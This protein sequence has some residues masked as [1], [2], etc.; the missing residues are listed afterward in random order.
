MCASDV[1]ILGPKRGE[2]DVTGAARHYI[3]DHVSRR[4]ET[5]ASQ[6]AEFWTTCTSG[7]GPEQ[8]LNMEWHSGLV[9]QALQQLPFMEKMLGQW[10]RGD[11]SLDVL[12]GAIDDYATF[13]TAAG[14]ADDDE[15][16]PVPSDVVDLLW[17]THMLAPRRYAEECM[18]ICGRVL[19]HAIAPVE[20]KRCQLM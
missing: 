20:S 3:V 10:Q 6:V 14:S 16:I 9:S 11:V 4:A 17:H 8:V 1:Y 13:L 2:R 18:Q 5:Y 19:D 7:S 15:Q 12:A